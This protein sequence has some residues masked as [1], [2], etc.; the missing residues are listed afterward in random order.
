[1]PT[2]QNQEEK[3]K[4]TDSKPTAASEAAD[5]AATT[6][7]AGE[8][9]AADATQAHQNLAAKLAAAEEQANGLKDQLLRLRAD[10]E[11]VRRRAERDVEAA[12]KF[13]LE[14]FAGE[15]LPVRDSLE[16]G[17][18]AASV[19]GTDPGKLRE[20]VDLTLKMLSGVLEKFGI[21][22]INP[23][24]Q[25]FNPELHQAM[26]TQE[27]AEV[28]PNTVVAVYQKGYLLNERLLRPAL[29]VVSKAASGGGNPPAQE[30]GPGQ[31]VD[32]TA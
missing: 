26:T 4:V 29:V 8:A 13:A 15:L 25:K 10:T 3:Q 7:K 23:Q 30:G 17:L 14:R 1:V 2:P 18:Q 11:N 6:N 19:A 22:E 28:D 12:H 21:K 31:H 32:E 24:K 27:T 5:A 9:P 16:L 20:G